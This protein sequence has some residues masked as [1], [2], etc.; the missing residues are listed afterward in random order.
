MKVKSRYWIKKCF[1]QSSWPRY[2]IRT[3]CTKIAGDW[4]KRNYFKT[5][6]MCL[7][8]HSCWIYHFHQPQIIFLT[9]ILIYLPIHFL[10][11]LVE[12][13]KEVVFFSNVFAVRF[14][15]GR[16]KI[17]PINLTGNFH[18]LGNLMTN[19]LIKVTSRMKYFVDCQMAGTC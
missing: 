1:C 6:Q 18:G 15:R 11:K 3:G 9:T 19:V 13:K 14:W 4:K 17:L 8:F 10:L 2:N 12:I 5:H 7:L 16:N